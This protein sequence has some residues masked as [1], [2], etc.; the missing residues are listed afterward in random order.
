MNSSG[1]WVT[2]DQDI[3]WCFDDG[4]RRSQSKKCL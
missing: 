2:T 3:I 4:D 1:Y